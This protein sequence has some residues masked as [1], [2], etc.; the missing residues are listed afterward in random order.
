MDGACGGVR[1]HGSMQGD[2]EMGLRKA[3]RFMRG[4][5]SCREEEVVEEEGV[6]LERTRA[7]RLKALGKSPE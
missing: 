1:A 3:R 5:R 6:G 4:E 7:L 2:G